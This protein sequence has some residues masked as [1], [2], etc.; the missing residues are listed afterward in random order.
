MTNRHLYIFVLVG[1]TSN[2]HLPLYTHLSLVFIFSLGDVGA[3][4]GINAKEYEFER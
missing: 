3:L 2:F 1:L 4:L